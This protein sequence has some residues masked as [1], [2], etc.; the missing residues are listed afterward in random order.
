MREK[1][2]ERERKRERERGRERVC[3]CEREREKERESERAGA[4]ERERVR[5]RGWSNRR[6]FGFR[7]SPPQRIAPKPD[8]TFIASSLSRGSSPRASR[9]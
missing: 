5:E 3:V 6:D 1:E 7:I 2:R 8:L 4:R 9:I